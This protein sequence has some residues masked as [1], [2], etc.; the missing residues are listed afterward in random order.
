[1]LMLIGFFL[2]VSR[3][4]SFKASPEIPRHSVYAEAAPHA[5][6]SRDVHNIAAVYASGFSLAARWAR[7]LWSACG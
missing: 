6:I 5:R 4:T 7:R 3:W 1:M 2:P